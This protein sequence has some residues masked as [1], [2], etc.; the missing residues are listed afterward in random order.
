MPGPFFNSL[1]YKALEGM[2]RRN[3]ACIRVR[4]PRSLR[5]SK[6]HNAFPHNFDR[7]RVNT[8]GK[9]TETMVKLPKVWGARLT[10]AY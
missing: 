5:Q 8:R 9:G 4:I 3:V 6:D 1:I 7:K 10:K 2:T